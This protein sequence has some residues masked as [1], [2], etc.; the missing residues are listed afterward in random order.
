MQKQDCLH[1]DKERCLIGTWTSVE[2]ERAIELG[3][4]VVK[5]YEV[6]HW[7]NWD[8]IFK[9][10]VNTIS[11]IKIELIEITLNKDSDHLEAE[12]DVSVNKCKNKTIILVDDVLNSGRT[13]VYGLAVFLNIP[14]KKK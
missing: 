2:L 4:K 6:W 5:I 13:L 1:N 14:T 11:K 7:D 12:V 9:S 8:F 3:Y 10:Y